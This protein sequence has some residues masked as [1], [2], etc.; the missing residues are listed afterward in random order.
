MLLTEKII[1]CSHSKWASPEVIVK[2]GDGT[3]RFYSDF[4][5]VNLISKKDAY[6][7]PNMSTILDQLRQASILSKIYLRQDYH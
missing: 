5:K 7:L 3:Y 6:P 4:R 2:K 1:E